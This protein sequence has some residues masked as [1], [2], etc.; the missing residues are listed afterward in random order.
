M[1]VF[2]VSACVWVSF[3]ASGQTLQWHGLPTSWTA[4]SDSAHVLSLSGPGSA[5]LYTCPPDIAGS[6]VRVRWATTFSGSQNNF[7]AFHLFHLPPGATPGDATLANGPPPESAWTFHIGEPGAEDGLEV[8]SPDGTEVEL[9]D[10]E[11]AGPVDMAVGWAW[12]AGGSS[13][14]LSASL[15]PAEVPP[16]P[17]DT[18]DVAA[19]SEPPNCIGWS[20]T[21]TAS[22]LQGVQFSLEAWEEWT[23][24]TLPPVLVGARLVTADTVVWTANE[25]LAGN[26]FSHQVRQA[27]AAPATPGVPFWVSSPAVTDLAGNALA[28][29][30][31][32]A[33]VVWTDPA[34]H[35]PGRVVISEILVD[36]TPSDWLPEA[37]WVEVVN[38]SA[39]TVQIADLQWFDASS[40]WSEILPL[41]PWD[42]TLGPG[43]RALL[44][45]STEPLFP[46]TPQAHL[47][48]GGSLSDYGDEIGL[49][50]PVPSEAA[51]KWSD[52]VAWDNEDWD[53]DGRNGRS[54][55]RR[56][57]KGCAG[58]ANWQAS[59]APL[60]A[61]PGAPGWF[62]A[63]SHGPVPA[64]SLE[65]ISLPRSST[66]VEIHFSEPMDPWALEWL[67]A[68]VSGQ[69]SGTD[70]K[71][72]ELRRNANPASGHAERIGGLRTCFGTNRG[73][74][75]T[76][77]ETE[78]HFAEPGDVMVTEI[79][80]EP[81]AG[82][83]GAP[84]EWVELQNLR[85]DSIEL[86]G[87][88]INGHKPIERWIIGPES[89]ATFH[90]PGP[91]DLA[92][93]SGHVVVKTTQGET[94]DSVRY[95]PCFFSRKSHIGKGR[96]MVRTAVG[97]ATSGAPD[98]AS[99][100]AVDPTE[101][102][103]MPSDALSPS[104][105]LC[106]QTEADQQAVALLSRPV[107]SVASMTTSVRSL[108]GGRAWALDWPAEQVPWPELVVHLG[109]AE[110]VVLPP[111]AEC[112][113]AESEWTE[114]Q[115][116]EVLADTDVEPF[117]EIRPNGGRISSGQLA[118]ST[119]EDPLSPAN[120][121]PL[122]S[123]GVDWFLPLEQAWA[124]AACPNRL[125]TIRALPLENMPSLWG[126]PV[127]SL[128]QAGEGEWGLADSVFLGNQRHAD[129]VRESHEIS[130]ERCGP[131]NWTSCRHAAGHTAGADNSTENWC[132]SAGLSD[133]SA[134][135]N[136]SFWWPGGPPLQI[137]WS[138]E[139]TACTPQAII[140]DAWSMREIQ[141][142]GA[143]V[144]SDDPR[145]SLTWTW[146][147]GTQYG[148]GVPEAGRY[149]V[150]LSGCSNM[151]VVNR[152]LP[153]VIRGP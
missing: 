97:W 35:G 72:F 36:P 88:S 90:F 149:L 141:D 68:E 113:I 116:S 135:L 45:T 101:A 121:Q 26:G 12:P 89:R 25:P 46:G 59:A 2:G 15:D 1:L 18:L 151:P 33:Q 123:H 145:P 99:P 32:S 140:C 122:T 10:G 115:L 56:Y 104:W 94:V 52:R 109:N 27:L 50:L 29:D 39:F 126:D 31:D 4:V 93:E 70:S 71:R 21:V 76:W 40:G 134:R 23:P 119:S 9:F 103:A 85:G 13:I 84:H 120:R 22:N 80:A 67:P 128:L 79:L 54:W 125:H 60:G 8:A 19:T 5:W 17:V 16:T 69:A 62:E 131:T 20:A 43:E 47:P 3:P 75:W 49:L 83:P 95:D 53:G 58:P 146:E 117:I 86:T 74:A 92:N 51:L 136:A 110:S 78:F 143:P 91:H 55:Q 129:W 132:T 38:V 150:R 142:L 64:D 144:P 127:V 61:T 112:G 57:L 14:A 107:E 65:W 6:A 37:E 44:T 42:G 137:V 41:A 11:L 48:D 73:A 124:F 102:A 7:S 98:G 139:S 152:W 111:P 96:S 118:M 81:L 114:V 147:G 106:G 28:A 153:F 87:L 105:I 100:G 148:S 77:P 133:A 66:E 30:S 34:L 63:D 138:S 108:L 24:D 82:S 130:L